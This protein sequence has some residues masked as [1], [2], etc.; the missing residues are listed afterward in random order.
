MKK[1]F[2][3]SDVMSVITRRHLSP[4]LETQY[5]LLAHLVGMPSVSQPDARLYEV[6]Q[7]ELYRQHPRLADGQ[8]QF[9]MGELILFLEETESG[10]K[11]PELLIVSWLSGQT[12]R[13]GTDT[14]EIE[15]KR[16]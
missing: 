15:G 6:A 2:P 13:L 7:E 1:S 11:E 14:F 16:N 4:T 5:K 9:A 10:K 3:I 8:M 12:A